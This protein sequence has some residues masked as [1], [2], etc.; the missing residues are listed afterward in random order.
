LTKPQNWEAWQTIHEK[1]KISAQHLIRLL[2]SSFE[3]D[4]R[5]LK[6]NICQAPQQTT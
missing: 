3:E 6:K 5:V 2:A 1:K 4:C